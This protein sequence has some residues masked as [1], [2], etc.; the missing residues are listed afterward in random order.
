MKPG[1][2][3]Y[4]YTWAAG[5]KGFQLPE[6]PFKA[7]DLI[8]RAHKL[9]VN[10]VQICDNMPLH[11]LES[12]RIVDLAK[13]ARNLNIE[14]EVGTRGVIPD[15]LRKYLKIARK[16]ESNLVRTI[17]Q[18][19]N[20][21]RISIKK[22]VELVK[23][24][25]PEFE[26]S[27]IKL[28]FENHDEYKTDDFIELVNK[29][30][31]R[32]VGICLDTVNSFG[33]LENPEKVINELSPYTINVHIKDFQISRESHQMGFSITGA[34]AGE[35]LLDINYL[36]KKIKQYQNNPNFILELWTP[37]TGDIEQ[38][39]KKEKKWAEESIDY[40]KSIM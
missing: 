39:V 12:T 35:G 20:G 36:I 10:L 26:N 4:T 8:K 11:K 16:F 38:T 17:I 3:S 2:S 25:L 9:N 13:L 31:S 30:D 32:F 29:V 34:P 40:L 1:I 21:E 18:G 37:F 23:K 7:K 28:A 5:V 33:A 22:A 27:G 24:V 6:K 19:E 14:V 15:H